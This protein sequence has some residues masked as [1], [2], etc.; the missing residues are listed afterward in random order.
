MKTNVV[1]F[2]FD[3]FGGGGT[4]A[5]AQLLA[6]GLRELLDDNAAEKA[7]TRA[8]AYQDQVRLKEF[9]FDK[10][11]AYENWR[12]D[13]RLAVQKYWRKSDFLLWIAGNHLGVLPIYD[14]L[15]QD[16]DGTLVIQFDAHL[17]VYNLA[18]CTT[19]LSHG[20]FLLHADGPLPAIIN[21]GHREL[22]LRPEYVRRYYQQTFSAA[23]L[24]I[25]PEPALIYLREACSGAKRV[26]LDIDCDVLDAAFFPA[27]GQPLP[28]GLAPTLLLR[29]LEA[30]W[31]ERLVGMAISEFEPGRDVNDRSLGTLLWLVEYL[32]LRRYE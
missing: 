2:P 28:F 13:A 10:L 25:D 5:G 27:Q 21:L 12:A 29:L 19:E 30:V 8:R 1:I 18:D 14:E 31:S 6:D 4:A 22:L 15:S 3:L 24:A 7:P 26:F 23:E 20:N 9:T 32:L 11:T 16:R 17:D